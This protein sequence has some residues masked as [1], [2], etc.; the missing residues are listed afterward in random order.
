MQQRVTKQA[1][2]PRSNS[3]KKRLKDFGKSI[4][5]RFMCAVPQ[6]ASDNNIHVNEMSEA[7][8]IHQG[9]PSMQFDHDDTNAI[10]DLIQQ[11]EATPVPPV[12]KIPTSPQPAIAP[13][14]L[15]SPTKR[16]LR[17]LTS[18]DVQ[19]PIVSASGS[20]IP[21]TPSMDGAEGSISIASS[22]VN[23]A[24][25]VFDNLGELS[26]Q[27]R[28]AVR[29]KTFADVVI[30]LNNCK[31]KFYAHRVILAQRSGYFR[32]FFLQ[33][34]SLARVCFSKFVSRSNTLFNLGVHGIPRILIPRR[35]CKSVRILVHW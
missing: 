12:Q 4:K 10:H 27:L 19:N 35:F 6:S 8:V 20:V 25:F 16:E 32:T 22:T 3:M 21:S 24:P 17:T 31:E 7:Q 28:L 30:H 11:A 18:M 29:T 33:D 9:R 34:N 15:F 5:N 13:P 14:I 1:R 23:S 26:D 2:S